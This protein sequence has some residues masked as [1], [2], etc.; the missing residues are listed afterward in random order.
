LNEVATKK[1]KAAG[2][3]TPEALAGLR[4]ELDQARKDAGNDA[5]LAKR[6]AFLELGLRWTEVEARAHAF[7][8]DVA[9]ADREAA[10]KTL[11]ER[12]ALMREIFQKAPLAVNV[13]YISWG[14][15]ALWAR[16]GW[17]RPGPGRK[18]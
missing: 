8:A 16:L 5:T 18:P 14:E 17:E 9:K 4:K 13:A 12:H 7:L 6:V 15:D 1:T 2:V 3:F 11:D 10:R